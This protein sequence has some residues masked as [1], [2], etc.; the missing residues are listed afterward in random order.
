[1][2]QAVTAAPPGGPD[3]A[4]AAILARA[5]DAFARRLDPASPAPLAI[6]FSGG[7]DSLALLLAARA[8][9]RAHGRP[10]LALTVDHGLNPESGAWTA[11]AAR[12]AAELGAGFRALN[13]NAAKPAAGLPAAARRARHALLAEAARQAGASVLLLGHT[14]D[15][16]REA[17][18]MRSQGSS[19]G[20]PREWAPSPAWPEGRG[21]FLLRPLLRLRR[22]ELRALLAGSGLDWI[23]DPANDDPGSL[24][25]LARRSPFEPAAAAPPP[26]AAGELRVDASGSVRLGRD[27]DRRLLAMACVC[28]GGGERLPRGDGLDRLMARLACGEAFVATLAGARIE[29]GQSVLVCRDP[30]RLAPPELAPTPGDPVVFDGRFV[31]IARLPGLIVRPLGGLVSRLEKPARLSLGAFP[32]W[33]RR[34]LPALLNSDGTVTCPILAQSAW[35]SARALVGDRLEAAC[36]RI[37]RESPLAAPS[38]G[39]GDTGALS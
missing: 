35:G 17:V 13:W 12:T 1:M 18:W 11:R 31:I 39:E 23:E 9:T 7:G 6:G 26:P 22:A 4:G 33:A 38:H 32:P 16:V 36:G 24:R 25:S 10:L 37:A 8:W 19:V 30:G 5:G 27:A 29:A 3:Q 21:V 20:A 2:L 34:S 14:H 15:D 28:A